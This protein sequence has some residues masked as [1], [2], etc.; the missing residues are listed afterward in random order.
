MELGEGLQDAISAFRVSTEE[1]PPAYQNRVMFVVEQ[2]SD[3]DGPMLPHDVYQGERAIGWPKDVLALQYNHHLAHANSGR[4][5]GHHYAAG[6]LQCVIPDDCWIVDPTVLHN[7]DKMHGQ[8]IHNHGEEEYDA[9]RS[10]FWGGHHRGGHCVQSST[11][12]GE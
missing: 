6:C 12:C 10:S 3:A 8:A 4:K 7:V 9:P 1:I 11:G 5:D 2:V